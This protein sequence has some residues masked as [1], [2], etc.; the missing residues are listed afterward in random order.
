MIQIQTNLLFIFMAAADFAGILL[1]VVAGFLISRRILKPIDRITTAAKNI[2]V[3]DL[4]SRIE[5]GGADDELT[6]LSVT[7]NEMLGRL[8]LSF[9]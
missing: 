2:S 3:T 9:E 5:A 8:R 1:S 7:F 6:R 4:N